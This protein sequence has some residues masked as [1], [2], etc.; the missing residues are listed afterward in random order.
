MSRV[1][2]GVLPAISVCPHR[3]ASFLSSCYDALWRNAL[4]FQ[5]DDIWSCELLNMAPTFVSPDDEIWRATHVCF[6]DERRTGVPCLLTCRIEL[7]SP[8]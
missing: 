4:L 1:G 2:P 5:L 7:S 6:R 8:I 3:R